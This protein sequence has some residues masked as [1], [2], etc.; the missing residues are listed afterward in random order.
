MR[1][2]RE[3]AEGERTC[4]RFEF[5]CVPVE[6]ATERLAG[7]WLIRH[8]GLAMCVEKMRDKKCKC[9][10]KKKMRSEPWRVRK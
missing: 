7:H 6:I 4:A 9:N 10:P 2:G 8:T 3:N 5:E 1:G